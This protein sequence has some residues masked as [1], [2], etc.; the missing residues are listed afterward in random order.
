MRILHKGKTYH[1]HRDGSIEVKAKRVDSWGVA[2]PV[3]VTIPK[4]GKTATAVRKI[5]DEFTE[6]MKTEETG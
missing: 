1:V 5:A 2:A 6:L 3:W 4:N